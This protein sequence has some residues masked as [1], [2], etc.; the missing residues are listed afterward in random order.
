MY[1]RTI[2][3]TCTI[4][5]TTHVCTMYCVYTA[6]ITVCM[7]YTYSTCTVLYR[8]VCM[9]TALC[10]CYIYNTV[11]VLYIDTALCAYVLYAYSNV[12]M[13][14]TAQ[15][16]Y[17]CECVVCVQVPYAHSGC[18]FNYPR[19]HTI[20]VPAPAIHCLLRHMYTHERVLTEHLSS[21]CILCDNVQVT[22]TIYHLRGDRY[23]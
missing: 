1:V 8:T 4:M 21:C 6:N 19:T 22:T 18:T 14:Y 3:N 20:P 23:R 9:C 10:V 5:C 16:I 15:Y 7:L 13:L 17:V 11:C 2:N 12:C